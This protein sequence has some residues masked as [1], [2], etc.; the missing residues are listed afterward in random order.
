MT[1][2][3]IDV[4]RAELAHPFGMSSSSAQAAA[5][6]REETAT[7]PG[8]TLFC[9]RASNVGRLIHLVTVRSRAERKNGSLTSTAGL[10][11]FGQIAKP[12]QASGDQRRQGC[13]PE[14]PRNQSS[15]SDRGAVSSMASDFRAV[16]A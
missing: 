9:A 6:A 15:R 13:W 7:P 2:V 16:V 8:A 4:F 10:R 11:C 12:A 14:P 5:Q 1:V 3:L